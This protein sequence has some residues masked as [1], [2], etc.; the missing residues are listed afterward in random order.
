MTIFTIVS[1][2]KKN[3]T[4]QAK[5]QKDIHQYRTSLLEKFG[6]SKSF[7]KFYAI[8]ISCIAKAFLCDEDTI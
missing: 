5:L 2:A 1:Y 8:D 7:C 4:G 6:I 3:Y